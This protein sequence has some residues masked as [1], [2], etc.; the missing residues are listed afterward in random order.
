MNTERDNQEVECQ[1]VREALTA[2]FDGVSNNAEQELATAHLARCSACA[3]MWQQWQGLRLM[4]QRA[5]EPVTSDEILPLAPVKTPRHLKSTIIRQTVAT[6]IWQRFWPRLLTGMAVPTF[7]LG[8]WLLIVA[9]PQQSI[10][11]ISAQLNPTP[12]KRVATIPNVSTKTKRATVSTTAK[13]ATRVKNKTTSSSPQTE[14]RAVS[15]APVSRIKHSARMASF[16]RKKYSDKST[17]KAISP[18]DNSSEESIIAKTPQISLA[19]FDRPHS[20]AV[21]PALDETAKPEEVVAPKPRIT[22]PPQVD[23]LPTQTPTLVAQTDDDNFN[24]VL[25]YITANDV[26]PKDIRQAVENYRAALLDDGSDL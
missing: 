17:F 18:S 7:A 10:P 3:Q 14:S 20:R 25:E 13:S 22:A 24:P 9:A 23:N 4:E 8:C 12:E 5:L 2:H 26:R 15:S 19:S 6:P 21:K 11:E 16:A 1:Q